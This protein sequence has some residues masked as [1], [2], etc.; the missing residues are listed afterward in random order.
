M[1]ESI[2][3]LPDYKRID[4]DLQFYGSL[5]NFSYTIGIS[6]FNVFDWENVKYVQY[7]YSIPVK[8]QIKDQM[9]KL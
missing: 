3:Y 5:K 4:T 8:I 1:K 6:I 2:N 7:I 9:K